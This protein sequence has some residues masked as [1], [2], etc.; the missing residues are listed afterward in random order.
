MEYAIK[1]KTKYTR[2]KYYVC[3]SRTI[4]W[5]LQWIYFVFMYCWLRLR[6]VLNSKCLNGT[7]ELFVSACHSFDLRGHVV[8]CWILW[9]WC[10]T[11]F[12]WKYG[13]WKLLF[14][15]IN[16]TYC[17]IYLNFL[18]LI[19]SEFQSLNNVCTWKRQTLLI[20]WETS[21]WI[22]TFYTKHNSNSLGRWMICFYGTKH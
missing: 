1:Y 6:T 16:T 7:Q 9:C 22:S 12:F 5:K 4:G 8:N 13:S 17:R 11:R 10:S 20:S 14:A 18:L 15:C 2:G 3:T 19:C 21:A